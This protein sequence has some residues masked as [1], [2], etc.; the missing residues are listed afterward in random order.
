MI[1]KRSQYYLPSAD[2]QGK[3]SELQE[4]C[5]H[6]GR[7]L[8]VR[9]VRKPE[10]EE[11][12]EVEEEEEPEMQSEVSNETLYVDFEF[13]EPDGTD[14]AGVQLLLDSGSWNFAKL[15]AGGLAE[16]IAEQ[17]SNVGTIAKA[18]DSED[19]PYA[20]FTALNL[21]QF[22][23]CPWAKKVHEILLQ[24]VAKFAERKT[25]ERLTALL[26]FDT[27]GSEVGLIISDR[28]KELPP[29]IVPVLVAY[30]QDDLERSCTECPKDKRPF[31]EFSHFVLLAKGYQSDNIK[32]SEDKTN[33][34]EKKRRRTSMNSEDPIPELAEM[35]V[36]A[37]HADFTFSFPVETPGADC[38]IVFVL[39]RAGLDQAAVELKAAFSSPED[40]IGL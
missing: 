5:F 37:K 40:E 15:D 22:R 34:P 33:V 19:M 14:V 36:L 7:R 20:L 25:C 38:R 6:L 30:F 1:A 21:R 4:P 9:R 3:A 11:E 39:S 24:K 29:R 27:P 35:E 2:S 16:S 32:S 26:K 13:Q 23:D 8:R 18:V 28:F 12:N 17:G 10:R 31:Y